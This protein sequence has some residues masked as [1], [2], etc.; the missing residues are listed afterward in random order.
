MSGVANPA[1]DVI[2]V[3]EGE[4]DAPGGGYYR[5]LWKRTRTVR[6]LESEQQKGDMEWQKEESSEG[7][8]SY[9][10]AMK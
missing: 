3:M 4:P 5:P 6:A 2:V 10:R 1:S 7:A 8:P 9:T